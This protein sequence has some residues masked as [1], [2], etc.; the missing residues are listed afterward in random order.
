MCS[1]ILINCNVWD[2]QL[3]WGKS[4]DVGAQLRQEGAGQATKRYTVQYQATGGRCVSG[5]GD[6]LLVTSQW[7]VRMILKPEYLDRKTA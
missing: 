4:V 1:N 5:S 7:N 3:T 6:I 2:E